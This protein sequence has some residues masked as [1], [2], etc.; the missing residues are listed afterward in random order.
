M[1]GIEDRP[2]TLRVQTQIHGSDS[3]KPL[4][5]DSGIGLDPRALE[6]EVFRT[7]ANFV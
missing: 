3:V 6:W 4:V 7:A 5:R 1:A 2:R